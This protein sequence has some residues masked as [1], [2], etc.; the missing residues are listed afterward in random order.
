MSAP[1]VFVG[2]DVSKAQ[3]DVAL[4]PTGE[5]WHV[6]HDEAGIAG[7]AE[8][9]RTVQPALIVL[10]A[11][12]GLE[13]PVTGA[14]AEAGLPV[15]VVN[16]RHARDF[17]KA[18]GRLAK[19]DTLDA[20]GLAHFAEAVRP[21]PR[22][23]PEAQ[24]QALSAVLTRRR[25]LVQM[26]TAERQRLQT[27]PQPVRADI[28]AHITWLMRRLARTDAD[29]AAAV[30]ASPLWRAKDEILRST[31]GVGPILSRTL[32][33]EVPEL[34]VLNRQEI[35]ALIGV[36]PFNDDRGTLRGKRV[37]WGGRAHV[38]AVLYMSTLAAVRHNAVLKAFYTRLRAVGKAP[39]VAL[40]A[41]M[42][43]LLTMLN[44]MLKH[45]TPWRENYATHS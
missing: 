4:R 21:T 22:P 29:V 27:A 42:R 26:L 23:L 19:T 8:R 2:I 37:V 15:V 7:L 35:A 41:C 3:L 13:V 11:S 44:A 33:A 16:P 45:R 18:T 31:P 43:K 10:E 36:A 20:R 25:R 32:V 5:C 9:L 24:A 12:G 17:A 38:R 28:Q 40:T 34:G 14:L 30:H 6:N 39:K 1:Q